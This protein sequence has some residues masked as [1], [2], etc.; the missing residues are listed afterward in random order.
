MQRRQP[1][2]GLTKRKSDTALAELQKYKVEEADLDNN[3]DTR[4]NVVVYSDRD[5][6]K[7]YSIDGYQLTSGQKKVNQRNIYSAFP[8]KEVWSDVMNS[9]LKTDLK[10]W[11]R[12][13][14]TPQ[15][16]RKYPFTEFER[17]KPLFEILKNEMKDFL[18]EYGISMRTKANP[19][20]N[21]SVSHYMILLQ[22]LTSTLNRDIMTK[23]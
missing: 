6:G 9:A 2:C 11:L 15:Q 23:I 22:K 10:A 16:Q 4:D 8:I 13:Y 7:I 19:Q 1:K 3:P 20:G 12:K 21:L 18:E 14:P 5:L 17:Q